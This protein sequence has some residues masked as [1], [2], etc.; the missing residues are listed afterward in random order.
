MAE[1]APGAPLV[2]FTDPAGL[3]DRRGLSRYL[4]EVPAVGVCN[5][6]IT[7]K[8]RMVEVLE[9]HT[10]RKLDPVKAELDTLG[11][12]HLSW[13]R[14]FTYEGEDFWPE[15]LRRLPGRGASA[16]IRPRRLIP[17]WSRSWG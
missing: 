17:G 1:P 6:P 7:A 11:L 15:M 4:P 5:V 8:M 13:R 3:G 16:P 10:G 12:D 14:G 9:R 2:N